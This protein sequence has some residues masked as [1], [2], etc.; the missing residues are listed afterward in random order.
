MTSPRTCSI[1]LSVVKFEP[2]ALDSRCHSP[3]LPGLF[4]LS[5]GWAGTEDNELGNADFLDSQEE[6]KPDWAQARTLF[7]Q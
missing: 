6:K 7:E 2:T 1:Q 3:P 5:G 4:F